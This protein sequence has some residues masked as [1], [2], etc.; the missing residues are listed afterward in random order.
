M[1]Q[2]KLK[3]THGGLVTHVYLAGGTCFVLHRYLVIGKG[4]IKLPP[5][6]VI[7]TSASIDLGAQN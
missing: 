1:Y 5:S 7:F 2:N 3:S 4:I 6:R